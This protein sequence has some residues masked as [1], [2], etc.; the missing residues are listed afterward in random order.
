MWSYD[1][2]KGV[3]TKE[4][5]DLVFVQERERRREVVCLGAVEER[6]YLIL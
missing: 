4:R 1:Q 5:E 2:V 3:C 6:V